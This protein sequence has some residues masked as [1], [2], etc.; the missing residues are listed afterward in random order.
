[1]NDL[2]ER[3]QALCRE[4]GCPLASDHAEDG[5]CTP[6]ARKAPLTRVVDPETLV[7]LV[8]ALLLQWRALH[9]GERVHLR[10]ELEGLGVDAD[11]I[12]IYTACQKLRRRYR[13]QIAADERIAGHELTA[14]PYQFSRQR[15]PQLR[16]FR[17]R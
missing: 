10:Q 9:R 15:V 8:A 11:H 5:I 12:D 4:C 16:L 14:W 6:C 2:L 13:W 7:D 1:M 3:R 17:V